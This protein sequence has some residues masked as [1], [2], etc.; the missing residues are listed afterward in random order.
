MLAAPP[1]LPAARCESCVEEVWSALKEHDAWGV[2]SHV[3]AAV[4]VHSRPKR[5]AS[6]QRSAA[7]TLRITCRDD[8]WVDSVWAELQASDSAFRSSSWHSRQTPGCRRGPQRIG[9]SRFKH[10]RRWSPSAVSEALNELQAC[11]LTSP[12]QEGDM[13]PSR[14][15]ARPARS[16]LSPSNIISML[17]LG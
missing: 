11:R 1:A 16:E 4:A 8:C 2:Q 6:R 3:A 10:R 9:V 15:A 14:R 17:N 7:T 13:V 5:G 12:R